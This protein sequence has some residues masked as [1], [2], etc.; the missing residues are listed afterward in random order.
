MGGGGTISSS[1]TKIESLRLQSSTYGATLAVVYGVTRV[2]GNML[3][4]GGFKA[5][6]H[7]KKQRAG[8]GGGT[9]IKTT[10]YTYSAHVAMAIAEGPITGIPRIWRGKSF[11]TGGFTGAQILTA[12][13]SYT[14]PGGG[15]SVTVTNSASWTT[16]AAVYYTGTLD[17][18]DGT[19]TGPIFLAEGTDYTVAAGVYTFG[20][21]WAGVAMSIQYQYTS[22]GS[23]VALVIMGLTKFAGRVGQ[24]TWSLL[25]GSFPSEAIPYSGIAYVAG[26]DYDLGS[27]ATVQNHNFEVQARLAYHL[28]S[29]LPD[30]DP[31]LVAVDLLTN[32]RYG[33]Q[34]P[35]AR[36]NFGL[37]SR[38][39]RAA[40]LLLSP[41]FTEQSS[42]AEIVSKLAQLT[43]TAPVWSGGALKMIPY[44]DA[45]LTANGATYTPDVTPLYDL[46]DSV[47]LPG[48]GGG[49]PITIALKPR[50]DAW[51]HVRIEYLDRSN[52]YN[53]AVAEAKD[54][55]DVDT[56][57]L[58]SSEVIQAHWINDATIARN[59]AQ[60][61]LQRALFVRATYQFRLPWTFAL[62]E[63][64]NLVTLTDAGL[65]LS[66]APARILKIEEAEDG[67]L[68]I[69]AEEFPAGVAAAALYASEVGSGYS[70]NYNASPGS[71]TAPII[72]EA[73]GDRTT[74]GLEVYAAVT[75]TGAD[76]GG[77]DVWVSLDGVSYYQAGTL[78]GGSRYGSLTGAISGGN[79]PVSIH[80]GELVA[81][82][83]TDAAALTSLCFIG[84]SNPEYLSHQGAT[85]TGAQAYTLSGLVRAAYGTTAT[86]HATSDP[87]V[88]VDDA[89]AKSGPLE[90][91]MIGETIHFKFTSFNVFGGGLEDLASVTD[92]TYTITGAHLGVV[93]PTGLTATSVQGGIL[94]TIATSG[95]TIPQNVVFEVFEHAAQ[96]PFASATLVWTGAGNVFLLPRS[97]VTDRYYWVRARRGSYVSG[98]YP[99]TNGLVAAAGQQ[100]PADADATTKW[101][102]CTDAEFLLDFTGGTLGWNPYSLASYNYTGGLLGGFARLSPNGTGEP[103]I[104]SYRYARATDALIGT[105]PITINVR[106]R[107][108][109][110]LTG[111]NKRLK[112]S[113]LAAYNLGGTLNYT[114]LD[115]AYLDLTNATVGTWYQGSHQLLWVRNGTEQLYNGSPV[116]PVPCIK[117]SIAAA[118]V[119]AGTV[120]IDYAD[121][122]FGTSTSK[123][124]AGSATA[125][126]TAAAE[127]TTTSSITHTYTTGAGATETVPSGKTSVRIRVWGGGA[128]G[129]KALEVSQG[130]GGGGFSERTI[131]CTAG[132]TLT[133]TVGAAVSGRSSNGTGASGNASSVS[134][135]VSG[136][137]VSM[138]A[139]GGAGAGGGGTATGGTTNYTGTAGTDPAGGAGAGP[140]GSSGGGAGGNLNTAGTAPGGGGGGT[141]SGTSGGGARG[142]VE[143]YYA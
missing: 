141:Y 143:F 79:L 25:S 56:F 67:E 50:A 97:T 1:E 95:G 10:T 129:S 26:Q 111:A 61:I 39:C 90:L 118:D 100:P 92:Y 15:G 139:N 125:G 94:F 40:G 137:S 17:Q 85:L 8:K 102:I 121:A 77:C 93:P 106:Y 89:L 105:W 5:T 128:A 109:S 117:L 76:W 101:R 108:N 11:E 104:T 41:A 64:M 126:A 54:Q 3:W 65:G 57:G 46:D 114:V 66:L 82:S 87:F 103:A 16:T 45:T 124:L 83:A 91:S 62:L 35:A 119:S 12:T 4:Y 36:L 71:V 86:A 58:R 75:G 140:T 98:T 51:N 116:P 96:T 81:A 136:G 18:G 34:F 29:S 47:L 130:G 68:A 21:A 30:A 115:S 59:V 73:P 55:A 138:T 123:S 72:F 49:E 43:N 70:Q 23:E 99:T 42:A 22:G 2:P 122:T 88:R 132:N 63:P 113:L 131:S 7:T 80:T 142:Q 24:T 28:G 134:G 14:V 53:V 27:D 107:V 31:A 48:T 32:A 127:L 110:T 120:D 78:Y 33:A 20:A 19:T 74:T 60:L 6:P 38:Y 52:D 69:E 112:V 44:G 135:T 9:T 37:W 84:G 13:H 133:Y